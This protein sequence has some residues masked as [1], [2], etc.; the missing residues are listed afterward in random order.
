MGKKMN[1]EGKIIN[2][3]GDSITRGA[4]A[5]AE[6][7][8]Y[9]RVLEQLSGATV[10]EWAKSGTRIAKQI[11]ATN[12]KYDQDFL[13]RIDIMDNHCD[14]V[15]MFGGTND[16]GHGDAPLGKM[17]D[18][19]EYTFYGAVKSAIKKIRNK[20]PT[21]FF[22]II[23]PLHRTCENNPYGEGMK[24]NV[25]PILKEYVFALK[26]VASSFKIPVL[27]LF[28]DNILTLDKPEWLS[29]DG[30]HPNNWGHKIIAQKIVEFL[31]FVE[32]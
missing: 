16:F 31:S 19:S 29:N 13:S 10:V 23:T 8:K 32:A 2:I 21:A 22:M 26:A 30:T 11:K 6:E 25:S 20:F 24:E 5:S 27:D 18:D 15:I 7:Y 9:I 1:L 14:I 12:S 4:L 3:I 28:D 17:G